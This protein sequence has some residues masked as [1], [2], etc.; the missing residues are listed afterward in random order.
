MKKYIAILVA[1]LFATSTYAGLSSYLD[2]VETPSDSGSGPAL[3]YK[4]AR[5]PNDGSAGASYTL[6]SSGVMTNLTADYWENANSA[7]GLIAGS[8]P[9][10]VEGSTGLFTSGTN[11]TVCFM[12]KTPETLSGFKSLF[13]QGYYGSISQFEI[14]INGDVLRLG[15]QTG[16]SQPTENLG[17]LAP[18]TWYYFAMTWDTSAPSDN[19]TWYYGEVGA[20]SMTSGQLTITSAGSNNQ[21][22]YFA[23]RKNTSYYSLIGGYYQSIAVYERTLSDSAVQ[24]QF[25]QLA[26]VQVLRLT[27]YEATVETPTDGGGG[28]VLYYPNAG[29]AD[30]NGHMYSTGSD[31]LVIY[32]MGDLTGLGAFGNADYA[33][34]GRENMPISGSSTTDYL[35]GNTGTISF[36]FKTPTSMTG[37]Q[38]LFNRGIYAATQSL[39]IGINSGVLRIINDSTQITNIG[40][41]SADTWYYFALRFDLTKT[42]D[43]LTWYY[44]AFGSSLLSGSVTITTS[45]NPGTTIYV[46]GRQGSGAFT[47]LMQELAT[48]DR[49]LSEQAII[50]QFNQTLPAVPYPAV[51]NPESLLINGDFTQSDNETT[52]DLATYRV[53]GSN[54]DYPS[55]DGNY[56]DVV[57]WTHYNE[58]PNSLASYTDTGEVLDG[59]DKLS[60]SFKPTLGLI[61]LSSIMDYRNGMIQTN[62]L[63]GVSIDP[64]LDYELSVDIAQVSSKDHSQTVFT[65]ALTTGSG[66]NATDIANVVPGALIQVDPTTNLPTALGT[67]YTVTISGS[68]LLAAKSEGPLNVLFDSLNTEAIAN[69]PEGPIDPLNSDEMSQV[70][71][72]TVSLT[73]ITPAGDGNKDGVV[74][75]DDLL[76][77]QLYLSG[78]GGLSAVDRQSQLYDLG[79]TAAE[80]LAY[81]NLEAYDMDGD[82]DFD[83][84][85]VTAMAAVATSFDILLSGNGTSFDI[86]WVS[87]PGK[88]Y[89]LESTASLSPASWTP[90]QSYTNIPADASQT[91]VISGI[92][93]SELSLFF[94]VIEK[95]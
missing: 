93:A 14:G 4:T 36:L 31:D 28:P 38:S 78:D 90:Y 6:T 51:E 95:D 92:P 94:K 45:G 48:W 2:S 19:L 61:Y 75:R 15:Y 77:A 27:A 70:F 5:T 26:G 67:P 76:T 74:G 65:A 58:D 55:N 73:M 57:G 40:S 86:E 87:L 56:A 91:N 82:N 89:D 12:F 43:D 18:A 34:E 33:V 7:F 32:N 68:D 13:N 35:T 8:N 54:G 71:L 1:A 88:V 52:P 84:D 41:L 85:D 23:G 50:D 72:S 59:T 9:A 62:I 80:A 10:A 81:L 29:I 60:T 16:T 39:E 11:G 47:G 64:N 22:V 79:Y 46:G 17:T 21:A 30:A 25:A 20:A 3:W 53:T 66:T 42:S 44:G 83:A 69:F 63:D 37:Y 24:N 49:T